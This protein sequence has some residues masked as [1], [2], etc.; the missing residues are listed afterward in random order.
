MPSEINKINDKAK[1]YSPPPNQP[2]R[3]YINKGGSAPHP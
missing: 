1:H 3:K 2:T